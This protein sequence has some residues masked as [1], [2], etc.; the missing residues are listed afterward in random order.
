MRE[1]HDEQTLRSLGRTAS[2]ISRI[3]AESVDGER[4]PSPES[5]GFATR[6]SEEVVEAEK[7]AAFCRSSCPAYLRV[8]KRSAVLAG[9][10]TRS[11][12]ASNTS[13]PTGFSFAMTLQTL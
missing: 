4:A 5:V 10:I 3:I 6:F 13:S 11:T 8:A 12:R 1:E 2:L 9:S 7:I